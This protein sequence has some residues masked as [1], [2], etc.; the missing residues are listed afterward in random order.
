MQR[1]KKIAMLATGGSLF[2]LGSCESDL[3][4]YVYASLVDYLPTLLE[5]LLDTATTTT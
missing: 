2:A 4:Y 5:E 3:A 1:F